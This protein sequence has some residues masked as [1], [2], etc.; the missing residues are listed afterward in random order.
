MRLII[1]FRRPDVVDDKHNFV[2]QQTSVSDI[3][4]D[5]QAEEEAARRKKR[6]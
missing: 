4:A 5:A 1:S 6:T 2:K 3:Q